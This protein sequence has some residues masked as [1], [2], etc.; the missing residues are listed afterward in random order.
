MSRRTLSSILADGEIVQFTYKKQ[1]F[2]AYFQSGILVN[3]EDN[4]R[5]Y[6]SPTQFANECSGGSHNGWLRC[7]VL[8]E[9]SLWKLCDLPVDAALAANENLEDN[10]TVRSKRMPPKSVPKVTT[11]PPVQP[12]SII[13]SIIVSNEA[14]L[15]VTSI[16]RVIIKKESSETP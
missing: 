5:T 6:M 15:E 2:Q 11:L 4:S 1:V 13:A 12:K 16:S 3:C 8:R 14:P 10:V 7:K 9:G